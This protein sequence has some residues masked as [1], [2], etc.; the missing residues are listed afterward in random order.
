MAIYLFFEF[1]ICLNIIVDSSSRVVGLRPLTCWDCRFESRRG[2]GY[3]SV[4]S[5]VCCQVAVTTTG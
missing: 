1:N 3:L 2:H 5:V 4:V